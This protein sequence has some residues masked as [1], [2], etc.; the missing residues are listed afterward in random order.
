MQYELIKF[1]RKTK[2]L[3]KKNHQMTMKNGIFK[4][5]RE[6]LNEVVYFENVRFISNKQNK[7]RLKLLEIENSFE[8]I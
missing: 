3:I 6:A 7:L 5:V 1:D 8:H 4:N 2:S